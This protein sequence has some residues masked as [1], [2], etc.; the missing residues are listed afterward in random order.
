MKKLLALTLT[1]IAVALPAA[2]QEVKIRFAHSLST[3]EPAHLAAE[4]FA[5]NVAE[6]TKGRVQI[7]VFPGEQLGP[8]KDI[9]EMIR[10]GANVMNITDPGY[11]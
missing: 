9:N 7:Q 2:A 1:A 5:K 6:R 8:G 4:Y 10:Q 11:L 3:T